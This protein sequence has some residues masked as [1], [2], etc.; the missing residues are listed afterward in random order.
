MALFYCGNDGFNYKWNTGRVINLSSTGITHSD[1]SKIQVQADGDEL[2]LIKRLFT[3][4]P[5]YDGRVV[6]WY[7]ETAAFI[8]FNLESYAARYMLGDKK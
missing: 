2:E 4:I 1:I 3:N 7:G 6:S 8:L 5:M